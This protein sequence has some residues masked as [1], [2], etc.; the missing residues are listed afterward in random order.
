MIN[1]EIFCKIKSLREDA[2]TPAHIARELALD[3]RTVAKWF[4]EKQFRPRKTGSRPS[5]LDPFKD[6][7]VRM[8]EAH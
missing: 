3:P 5:K 6:D 8:L 7:I 2:L 1:Y 4:E